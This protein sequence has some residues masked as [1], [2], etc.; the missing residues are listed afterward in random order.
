MGNALAIEISGRSA[1]VLSAKSYILARAGEIR[2]KNLRAAT[3][4]AIE[5][6][7]TSHEDRTVKSPY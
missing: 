3:L 2:D 6:P 5:N 7:Q 1:L 4:D